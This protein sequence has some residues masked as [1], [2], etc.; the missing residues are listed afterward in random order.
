MN[1]MTE[2]GIIAEKESTDNY[3]ASE[4]I[5]PLFNSYISIKLIAAAVVWL[6]VYTNDEKE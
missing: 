6:A 5:S 1:I 3:T 4:L 2:G